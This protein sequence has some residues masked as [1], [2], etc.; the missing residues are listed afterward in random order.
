MSD[1][2]N[3]KRVAIRER[4]Y[5]LTSAKEELVH[6]CTLAQWAR[7]NCRIASRTGVDYNELADQIQRALSL[8]VDARDQIFDALE[9]A[10]EDLDRAMGVE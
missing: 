2:N 5:V 1:E 10:S 3:E 7:D 9:R 4:F 8:L 6:V